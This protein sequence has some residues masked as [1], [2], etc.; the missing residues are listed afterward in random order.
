MDIRLATPEDYREIVALVPN[1][2]EL[3]LVYPKGKHPFTVSQLQELAESRK[4]LTV[5]VQ[6][7]R[8]VGFAN[9]YGL[10]SEKWVFIGNVV[11]Q[12]TFRG[13]GLGQKLVEHMVQLAFEKYRVPEVRISVFNSNVPALLLYGSLGFRPYDL[14]QRIDPEGNRVALIHMR[15]QGSE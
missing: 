1:R 8:V 13:S 3:Y 12:P 2:E 6:D 14:E 15:L 7:G 10:Q 5:A 4:E 9:L 11:I